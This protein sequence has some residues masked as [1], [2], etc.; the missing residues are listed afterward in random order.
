[1]RSASCAG[2]AAL[3]A[4][5]CSGGDRES[6]PLPGD[7]E[8]VEQ[9][10]QPMEPGEVAPVPT[11]TGPGP[12]DPIQVPGP[13]Q[14]P[15]T[16]MC[17]SCHGDP[18]S[19]NCQ[20]GVCI[21]T[22]SMTQLIDSGLI[23]PGDPDS[24]PLYEAIASGAMPPPGFSP[25]PSEGF[26]EGLRQYIL[27][28]QPLPVLCDNPIVSWDQLYRDIEA[29]LL[30]QPE[31][32]RPFLR[33]VSLANQ[34]AAGACAEE[35]DVTRAAFSKLLNSV[36]RGA[37]IQAPTLLS[38]ALNTGSLYRI[39]LRD[40]RLDTSAG[41]FIVNGASFEDGWDA[42]VAS[43]YYAV[44]LEGPNA[45]AAVVQSGTPVPVLFADSL[46]DV[47]S[48]G[49]VYYGLVGVPATQAELLASL[50]VDREAGLE[51]GTSVL[52]ATTTT[53]IASG[54][55][56][57]VRNPQASAGRYYYERFDLAAST[58]A[59][60]RVIDDPLGFNAGDEE[61]SQAL[62]S[63]PNGLLGYASFDADGSRLDDAPTLFDPAQLPRDPESLEPSRPIEVGV[64]CM[65]C[66]ERGVLSLADE[67]R[68]HALE[69]PD[70]IGDAAEAA[71]FSFDDVLDLYP[72]TAE[73]QQIVE[74]DSA[75]YL[76]ALSAA[77]A[78]VNGTEPIAQA[79]VRF[80]ADVDARVVASVLLLPV[81]DFLPRVNELDP[82]LS[83]LDNGF[84][85]DRDD[86]AGLYLHSLCSLEGDNDNRPT[87]A[88][89]AELLTP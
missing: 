52:A 8:A 43:D 74:A 32:D 35:L 22:L 2:V 85:V 53:P 51:Q 16:Q 56:L 24:S 20:G 47:A 13:E 77:G 73:L 18:G 76:A 37:A 14:P 48:V 11:G 58:S 60:G 23:V 21:G 46:I 4:L 39:D 75:P 86:F 89:C 7:D 78:P 42:I 33:Y 3:L 80:D 40:Y 67:A 26:I 68:E 83:G 30:S 70:A 65:G 79:F 57:V 1:M 27:R 84:K 10:P 45:D 41:P 38:D 88:S 82:A 71:G 69:N 49:E 12:T 17:G 54:Q 9:E 81:A 44:E 5:A 29:D 61:G 36:S 87:A 15:L 66:H 25:R 72:P 34:L 59:S 31:G 62:F 64:S 55:R 50:G 6:M 63:L 28:I 19:G